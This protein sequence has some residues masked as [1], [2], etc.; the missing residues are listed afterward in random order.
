MLKELK[1]MEYALEILRALHLNPG[2]H[3]SRRISELIEAGGRI[4]PSPSYVAKILPRMRKAGLLR[5]SEL[6]YVLAAPIDEIT[7]DSV[8]DICPMPES[9]SPLYQLCL[10]LKRAV[11]LTTID[12]FYNF[13]N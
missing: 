8:L 11:S 3:D 1:G 9:D 7:V 10:E 2:Q 6:G 5:S 13:T 12:E 4:D